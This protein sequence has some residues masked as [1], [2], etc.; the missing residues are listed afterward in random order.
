LREVGD[1]A[2]LPLIEREQ[3]QRDPEYFTSRAQPL[4][5]YLPLRS[6]G[7]TGALLTVFMDSHAL[8]RVGGHLERQRSIVMKLAGRRGRCRQVRISA[9]FDTGDETSRAF[10]ALSLVPASARVAQRQLSMLDPLSG[11]IERI[12][13]ER[14][15]VLHGWGSYIEALFLHVER[16]G[17]PFHRP[18]VVT[19]GADALSPAVRRLIGERYGARVLARYGAVEA[20]WIAFE[21]EAHRGLHVNVDLCPLRL[22]DAEG[23]QVGVGEPGQVVVSYLV[24]R[25][26]VLLNYR[27]GDL[28]RWLPAQCSCGRS[29]PLLSFLE[30]R[31]DDWVRTASGELVH[32]EVLR[33]LFG[34]EEQIWS[35]QVVQRAIGRFDVAVVPHAGSDREEMRAR[36]ARKFGGRFG[37]ATTVQIRFVEALPRTPGRKIRPVIAIPAADSR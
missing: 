33:T 20:F 16:N 28:A 19:Y 25:A 34:D 10:G 8:F 11:N 35:Y 3:L 26:T 24:N 6:G 23:R 27:L 30:G 29:L 31:R 22:V 5:S 2:R 36:L 18:K 14:P 37:D 4:D 32:P 13:R 21:C 17:T 1:L 9:P 7:S 15:D 12:N